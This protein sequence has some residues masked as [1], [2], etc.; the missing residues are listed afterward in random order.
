MIIDNMTFPPN[1]QIKN[2]DPLSMIQKSSV[3]LSPSPCTCIHANLPLPNFEATGSVAN[4]SGGVS[5]V[6]PGVEG[7]IPSE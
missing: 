6:L 4:R 3:E 5:M 2:C 1:T 7:S